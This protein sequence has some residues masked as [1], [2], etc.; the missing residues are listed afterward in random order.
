MFDFSGTSGA[1]DF[2]FH[3]SE[4]FLDLFF[5]RHKV[6]LYN[7]PDFFWIYLVITVNQKMSHCY[8]DFPVC[9]R[10]GIFEIKTEHIRCFANDFNI[11]DYHKIQDTVLLE[12][13]TFHV[14]RE[15]KDLVVA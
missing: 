5:K 7:I 12:V 6:L 4:I 10:V 13:L 2:L 3:F 15:F 1:F 14:L 11:L 9:F 8:D